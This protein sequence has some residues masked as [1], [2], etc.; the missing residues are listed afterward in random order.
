L[1][2]LS[3]FGGLMTLFSTIYSSL[4]FYWQ[5][6]AAFTSRLKRCPKGTA[7]EN[8]LLKV[9]THDLDG[10]AKGLTASGNM[11]AGNSRSERLR[12]EQS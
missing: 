1:T 2:V 4:R 8:V 3:L 11:I 10:S 5:K 12:N 7:T 6:K 9:D